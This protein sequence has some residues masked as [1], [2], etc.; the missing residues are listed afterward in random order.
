MD[1]EHNP[2]HEFLQKSQE[3]AAKQQ[4]ELNKIIQMYQYILTARMNYGEKT[5][6]LELLITSCVSLS[7]E[8]MRS[9]NKLSQAL[10]S[11]ALQYDDVLSKTKFLLGIQEEVERDLLE[12]QEE[13]EDHI[14]RMEMTEEFK[15]FWSN[16]EF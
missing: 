12:I 6:Q 4:E 11:Y 1:P 15:P 14:S 3:M 5:R 2:I 13:L 9:L 7:E 16:T 8:Y 10:R